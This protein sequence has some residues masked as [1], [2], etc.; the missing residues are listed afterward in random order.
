MS[1]SICNPSPTSRGNDK[2]LRSLGLQ[3]CWCSVDHV[4]HAQTS[5]LQPHPTPPHRHHH[6]T[7]SV[8]LFGH[9]EEEH[10]SQ[11]SEE[12]GW[13]GGRFA[14]HNARFLPAECSEVTA[15]ARGQSGHTKRHLLGSRRVTLKQK[16]KNKW[17][18]RG[19]GA[20]END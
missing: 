13:T 12:E 1:L 10:L 2:Y 17:R 19:D 4:T 20:V 15:G 18:R 6:L 7:P 16:R 9:A 3:R 14:A 8:S 5:L 11:R